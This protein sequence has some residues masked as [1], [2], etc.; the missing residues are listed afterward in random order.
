MSCEFFINFYTASRCI[1]QF[2][3]YWLSRSARQ[4][5]K[6]LSSA[7]LSCTLLSDD[8]ASIVFMT[9]WRLMSALLGK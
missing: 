6:Q 5:H 1:Q 2:V 3:L 9:S 4:R 8:C 7:K